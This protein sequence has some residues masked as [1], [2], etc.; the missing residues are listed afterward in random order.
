MIKILQTPLVYN[1]HVLLAIRIEVAHPKSKLSHLVRFLQVTL[2]QLRDCLQEFCIA[3]RLANH[4]AKQLM[5]TVALLLQK[6]K[7]DSVNG[8]HYLNF[9]VRQLM[10]K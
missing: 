1:L 2:G 4:F 9:K 3:L 5:R 8:L 7:F 10:L 6:L